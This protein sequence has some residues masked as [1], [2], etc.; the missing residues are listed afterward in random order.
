MDC[1]MERDE[2][3][4]R[5]T[6][7]TMVFINVMWG[8]SF[9]F[10]KQGLNAGF[11]PMGLAFSRYVLA[12]A[13]LIPLL[14]WREGVPRLRRE[15]ILP[16]F[17]SSLA[18]I[19]VYYFCEY[20]GIQR[21]STGSASLILAAIPVLTLG[22]E[23]LLTRTRLRPMQAAGA[24]LSLAGVGLITLSSSQEGSDSLAGVLFIFGASLVWVAYIF[25]SRRLRQRYSSLSM[26]AWQAAMAAVTLLPAALAEGFQPAAVTWD[27]WASAA[28]LALICSALCYYLYGNA[29]TALSPLASAIFV[30]LIPLTTMA[31]GVLF[32]GERLTLA[33]L[34][35]GA[36]IIG[37]IFL[38]NL[39]PA[40][41]RSAA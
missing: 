23:A 10:S 13:A 7:G 38:V 35:G 30:N 33:T 6:Y 12:A 25:L 4:M 22:A 2:A 17:L 37:S 24:F 8:L 40:A 29:L 19:T 1:M 5:K 21:T 41:G 27:G 18:G 28:V 14:L 31:A 26:N 36:L 9:I 34:A 16:M 15:D 11:Q 32:L 3:S 20:N 39:S